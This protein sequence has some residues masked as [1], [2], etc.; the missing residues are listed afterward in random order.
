MDEG[1]EDGQDDVGD[2]AGEGDF[3]GVASGILEIIGVKGRGFAPAEGAG[4]QDD[5]CA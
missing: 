1:E 4:D 3:G 2:G 5:Y